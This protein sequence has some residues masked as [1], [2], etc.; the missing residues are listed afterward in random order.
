MQARKTGLYVM[1]PSISEA[2]FANQRKLD[3]YTFRLKLW[4]PIGATVASVGIAEN[5]QQAL[6]QAVDLTLQRIR[7]HVFDHTHGGAFLAAAE[8]P[9]GTARIDV[10]F[11]DPETS[12]SANPACLRAEITYAADDRDFIG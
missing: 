9:A 3:G 12:M 10:R 7:G 5:E 8:G 6:D 1:R 11:L 2:R 4:W